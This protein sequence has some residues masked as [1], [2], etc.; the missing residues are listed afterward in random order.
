MAHL[1]QLR[2]KRQGERREENR[3]KEEERTISR[4]KKI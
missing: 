4:E 1:S 2:E 3:E